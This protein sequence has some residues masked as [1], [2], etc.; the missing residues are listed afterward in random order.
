MWVD[1]SFASS[2]QEAVAN[3]KHVFLIL[4]NLIAIKVGR[5]NAMFTT[6]LLKCGY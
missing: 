4:Q 3:K 2:F 6:E 5:N 1:A